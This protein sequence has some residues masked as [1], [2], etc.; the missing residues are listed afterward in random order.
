MK[1]FRILCG[2]A[3][4]L[5]A[6]AYATAHE[7]KNVDLVL[8]LAIDASGSMDAKRWKIQLEGYATALRSE[9]VLN[10]IHTGRNRAIA[11]EMVIWADKQKSVGWH[12]IHDKASAEAFAKLVQNLPRPSLGSSTDIAGAI[13]FS[14][15]LILESR[16]ATGYGAPRRVIDV[17]GDGTQNV[18]SASAVLPP[19]SYGLASEGA[20]PHARKIAIG[21]GITINGLAIKED[22]DSII[23][24]YY[25]NEVIGGHGAFM[26]VV[27]DANDLE[28]FTRAIR[29]NLVLEISAL[30]IGTKNG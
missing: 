30:E 17:S 6:S 12:I 28:L 29:R 18:M 1:L 2:I 20:L 23:H 25:Y 27:E 16:F 15:K 22:S 9:D 7:Q 14:T 10:A 13:S 19:A 26:L 24:Y 11:I 21:H 3:A 5:G 8:V 4:L